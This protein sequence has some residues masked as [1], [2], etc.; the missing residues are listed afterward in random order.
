LL[1]T[2]V[3]QT[4]QE[5]IEILRIRNKILLVALV[6]I[7]LT[8]LAMS[9]ASASTWAYTSSNMKTTYNGGSSISLDSSQ[10]SGTFNVA[11][12]DYIQWTNVFVNNIADRSVTAIA[13]GFSGGLNYNEISWSVDRS[14]TSS[15]NVF[16]TTVSDG[17]KTPETAYT[18]HATHTYVD[19]GYYTSP[20]CTSMKF[21]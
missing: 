2:G 19:G 1:D 5:M 10:P 13:S 17:S 11:T 21:Y 7:I 14:S 8:V 3:R 20:E 6:G 4:T 18:I 15:G 16:W 9:T 12:N